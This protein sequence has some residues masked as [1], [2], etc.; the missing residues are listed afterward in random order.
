MKEKP[1][2]NNEESIY[3]VKVTVADMEKVAEFILRAKQLR[4]ALNGDGIPLRVY[5]YMGVFDQALSEMEADLENV[6]E[7]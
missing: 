4:D 2:Q 6:K 5:R 7:A 3:H 1:Q